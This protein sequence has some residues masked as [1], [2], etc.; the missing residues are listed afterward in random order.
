MGVVPVGT[1]WVRREF[2]PKHAVPTIALPH[3]A[4]EWVG[5]SRYTCRVRRELVPKHAVPDIV[6]DRNGRENGTYWISRRPLRIYRYKFRLLNGNKS[7]RNLYL[8]YSFFPCAG[9]HWSFTADDRA[10]YVHGFLSILRLP[11]KRMV[12]PYTL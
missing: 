3:L 5:T 6:H 10:L 12:E 7:W 4:G 9:R 1:C 2:V 11:E 8:A